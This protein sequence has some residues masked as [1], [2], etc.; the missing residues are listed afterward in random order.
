MHESTG[1]GSLV[2]DGGKACLTN[3]EK[4]DA[5][6]RRSIDCGGA[7]G[8]CVLDRARRA[9]GAATTTPSRCPDGLAGAGRAPPATPQSRAVV[10]VVDSWRL[11]QARY[12]AVERVST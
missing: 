11:D 5:K 6:E 3:C 7:L 4:G 10:L 1:D 2:L 8:R 9:K 12:K